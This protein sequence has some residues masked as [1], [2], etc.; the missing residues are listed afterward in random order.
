[1]G[2][3]HLPLSPN[4]II[5]LPLAQQSLAQQ[6]LAQQSL[7]QQSLAQQSLAQPFTDLSLSDP[8]NFKLNLDRIFGFALDMLAPWAMGGVPPMPFPLITP[9]PGVMPGV[10]G[11][12]WFNSMPGRFGRDMLG[13]GGSISFT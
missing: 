7:A 3:V 8:V 13:R 10:P 9:I 2:Q 1:L 4:L 12:G 5:T 6:S 11:M